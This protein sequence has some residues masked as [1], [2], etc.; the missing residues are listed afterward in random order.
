MTVHE[1]GLLSSLGICLF[2]VSALMSHATIW[3]HVVK[4]HVLKH[5]TW[6]TSEL[7]FWPCLMSIH[8]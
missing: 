4:H 6:I 1:C 8:S 2:G 7:S 3:M 5:L